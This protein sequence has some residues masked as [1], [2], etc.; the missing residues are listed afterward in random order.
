MSK[1]R[2]KGIH[3]TNSESASSKAMNT[4]ESSFQY[5]SDESNLPTKVEKEE[6]DI[7]STVLSSDSD[8]LPYYYG[9]GHTKN[10]KGKIT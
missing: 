3:A 1:V 10:S 6:S 7:E 2:R 4:S 9:I 5:S 8:N